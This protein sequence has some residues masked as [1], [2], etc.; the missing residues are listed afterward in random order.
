MSDRVRVTVTVYPSQ[1]SNSDALTRMLKA[2]ELDAEQQL[3]RE[4]AEVS[5]DSTMFKGQESRSVDSALLATC[6]CGSCQRFF[7]HTAGR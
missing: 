6:G 5:F 7:S 3:D 4:T 1:P 2:Q